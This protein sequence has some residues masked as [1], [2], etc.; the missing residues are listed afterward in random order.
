VSGGPSTGDVLCS[1]ESNARFVVLDSGCAAQLPRLGGAA[2][3]RG[4]KQ[5]CSMPVPSGDQH[6]LQGG[7]CYIDQTTGLT[8]LCIQ[9]GNGALCY[10]DRLMVQH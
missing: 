2:L 1:T 4:E 7:Q 6:D 5:A 9:P 8:L 10:E 3:V